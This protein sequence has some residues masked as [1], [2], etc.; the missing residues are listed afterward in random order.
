MGFGFDQR[1]GEAEGGIAVDV[2][3]VEE[4]EIDLRLPFFQG[5]RDFAIGKTDPLGA[6]DAGELGRVAAAAR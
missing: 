4:G 5:Q 1:G 2:A 3:G 6:S